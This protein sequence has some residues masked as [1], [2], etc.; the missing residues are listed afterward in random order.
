MLDLSFVGRDPKLP[1]GHMPGSNGATAFAA[2]MLGAF[3]PL[4]AGDAIVFASQSASGQP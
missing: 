1:L 2:E 3:T 4:L